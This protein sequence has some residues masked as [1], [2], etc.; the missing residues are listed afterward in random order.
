MVTAGA[1]AGVATPALATVVHQVVF[2]VGGPG[3][4]VFLGLLLAGIA[5]T[6][7]LA[8]QLPRGLAGAML[9]VAVV[10]E[11]STLSLVV[12]PLGVLVAIGRFGGMAALVAAGALLP[13]RRP[14]PRAA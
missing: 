1:T 3:H 7:L 10:A 6:S 14:A 12:E 8:R 11:L 5:V 4:V 9:A 13:T 2:L